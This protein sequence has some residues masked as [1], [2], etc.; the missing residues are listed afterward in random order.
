MVSLGVPTTTH[1]I[2][3]VPWTARS[4]HLVYSPVR[5]TCI[6]MDF[7]RYLCNYKGR[8]TGNG[9]DQV[10]MHRDTRDSIVIEEPKVDS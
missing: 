5:V 9:S 4:P 3:I 10:S 2:V 8:C 7:Y 1:S 6:N